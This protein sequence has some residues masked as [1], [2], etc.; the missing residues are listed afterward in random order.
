V[1]LA[2]SFDD[3]AS[4]GLSSSAAWYEER[5]AGLGERFLPEVE[6]IVLLVAELHAWRRADHDAG[7]ENPAQI[8]P[9]S[10]I[11]LGEGP[12]CLSQV[13]EV[14]KTRR[15]GDT[16]ELEAAQAERQPARIVGAGSRSLVTRRAQ[17]SLAAH[18]PQPP[19]Q[20]P[21]PALVCL[22]RKV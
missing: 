1:T 14:E 7:I 15:L 3:D 21:R 10:A 16:G 12:T 22:L 2:V 20:H 19:P 17:Q 4:A 18:E 11:D 5:R 9:R 8:F 6:R 13:I